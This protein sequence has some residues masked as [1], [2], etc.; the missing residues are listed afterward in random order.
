MFHWSDLDGQAAARLRGALGAGRLPHAYLFSGPSAAP[1]MAAATFLACAINCLTVRAGQDGQD[2]APSDAEPCG[3][4]DACHKISHGLHPDV[5][6][7][8]REGAAQ[9]I[10]IETVRSQVIARLA[11]PPHEA[12]VRVFLVEEA[13]ALA[14]PAANALLKT[15]EEPPRRTLFVLCTIAPDGLLPTIRS[16]CQRVRFGGGAAPEVAGPAGDASAE[17]RREHLA[18]L[19]LEL[20]AP[21]AARADLPARIC[22]GKGEA[23]AVVERALRALHQRASEAARHGDLAAARAATERAVG[24]LDLHRAMTVHNAQPQLALEALL[25]GWRP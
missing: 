3:H 9:L 16:R 18:A 20:A 14:G 4:C 25:G 13:A 6:T 15:L 21:G 12:A 8:Q 24:L 11:L 10:P 2:G 1:Q 23:P 22:E 5:V 19:A 17:A 7:L